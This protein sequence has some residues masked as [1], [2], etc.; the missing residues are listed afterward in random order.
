LTITRSEGQDQ[1]FTKHTGVA[2][3]DDSTQVIAVE[4]PEHEYI[5]ITQAHLFPDRSLN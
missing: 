1:V 2:I 5:E 3:S 4:T